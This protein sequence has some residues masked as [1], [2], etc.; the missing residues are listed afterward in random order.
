MEKQNNLGVPIAI[1]IAGVLIAGA[2]MFRGNYSPNI[3]DSVKKADKS[4]VTSADHIIGNPNA[5]AI[6]IEY[7]DTECPYCKSFHSTM[8]R[9]MDTYGKNGQ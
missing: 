2:V 9:I 5:D 1:V 8:R 6:I 3:T 4:E 7:S